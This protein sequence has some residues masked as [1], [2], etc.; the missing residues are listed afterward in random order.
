VQTLTP[1][2]DA[3]HAGMQAQVQGAQQI[4]AAMGQLQDIAQQA[5]A[6]LHTATRAMAQL[7]EMTQN[8]REA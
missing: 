6:S 2:F 4:S 7:S 3:V 1:Q 8:L 5:I